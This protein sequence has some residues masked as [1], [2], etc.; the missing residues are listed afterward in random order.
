[1]WKKSFCLFLLCGCG[2][3]SQELTI[4]KLEEVIKEA[5]SHDNV[6]ARSYIHQYWQLADLYLENNDYGN[7][8]KIIIKGLALDPWNYKYQ[9]IAADIETMNKEYDRAYNRFNFIINNLK[10]LASIYEQSIIQREKMAAV[11]INEQPVYIPNYYVYIATYPDLNLDV[12]DLL[13][14]RISEEY[15]IEVKIINR[16]VQKLQFLNNFH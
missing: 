12:V 11:N 8:Y 9:K 7:A 2:L 15:G 13:A 4:D 6:N 3:F 16:V 1:M 14:A 5:E 10:D